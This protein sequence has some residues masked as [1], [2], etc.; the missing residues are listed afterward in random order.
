M[1]R[2]YKNRTNRVF[3]GLLAGMADYF[4]MDPAMLRVIFIFLMIF[5]GV[6]PGVLAYIIASAIVPPA[7][8]FDTAAPKAEPS[9][10]EPPKTEQPAGEEKK[11]EEVI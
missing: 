3:S 5:T 6:I 8:G 2:L 10:T 9:K 7:P 4:S 11:S 1:R